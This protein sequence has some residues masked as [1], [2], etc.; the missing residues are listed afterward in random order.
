VTGYKLDDETLIPIRE[1]D[2]HFVS[3]SILALGLLSF[4][5]SESQEVFS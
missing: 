3:I 5:C 4:L 2:F 1:K